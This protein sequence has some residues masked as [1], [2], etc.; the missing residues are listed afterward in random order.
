LKQKAEKPKFNDVA[1]EWERGVKVSNVIINR[2]VKTGD[3]SVLD[4][5]EVKERAK[6]EIMSQS[7]AGPDLSISNMKLWNHINHKYTCLDREIPLVSSKENAY[8]QLTID[9]TTK[10]QVVKKMRARQLLNF[11]RRDLER[12]PEMEDFVWKKPERVRSY[13]KTETLRSALGTVFVMPNLR[14]DYK[15]FSNNPR[16]Y[17]RWVSDIESVRNS[18]EIGSFDTSINESQNSDGADSSLY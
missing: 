15:M 6:E 17:P 1:I 18:S 12:Y 7:A 14:I 5:T 10:L 2:L 16:K 4:E 11:R 3:I 13:I 8:V 9:P